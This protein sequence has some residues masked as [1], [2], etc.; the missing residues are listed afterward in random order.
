[1][2][3][4]E[5]I[6]EELQNNLE[7]A[8]AGEGTLE[9]AEPE[10]TQT[11]EGQEPEAEAA[12]KVEVSEEAVREAQRRFTPAQQRLADE[13]RQ[14]REKREALE[15]TIQEIQARQAPAAPKPPEDPEPDPVLD[16]TA[17]LD[18]KLNQKLKAHVTPLAEELKQLKAERE[19]VSKQQKVE[20]DWNKL[21]T[22]FPDMKNESSEIAKTFEAFLVSTD[23]D[24]QQTVKAY[25]EG[26]LPMRN[27]FRAA[28][29]S[30]A[31]A[32]AEKKVK[33]DLQRKANAQVA[34]RSGGT[35]KPKKYA[36][37]EEAI[38]ESIREAEKG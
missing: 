30:M 28:V 35:P 18:W 21:V 36:S 22:E 1:M 32:G 9:Q 24:D 19:K 4:E 33:D 3:L 15:R 29:G 11:E 37:T 20:S 8:E 38:L 2:G 6:G 16:N 25:R 31:A 10:Q 12:P 27:L 26:H 5:V 7:P 17:W 14:E 13:L 34:G 23:P